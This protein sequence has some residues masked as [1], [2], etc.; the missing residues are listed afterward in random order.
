MLLTSQRAVPPLP[1]C[2]SPCLRRPT[3]RRPLSAPPTHQHRSCSGWRDELPQSP[4]LLSLLSLPPHVSLSAPPTSPCL[5]PPALPRLP[6]PSRSPTPPCWHPP[7]STA[8]THPPPSHVAL[9]RLPVCTPTAPLPRRSPTPPGLHPDGPPPTSLSP[10]SPC[11]Q[12][13]TVFDFPRRAC[14]E[15]PNGP[16]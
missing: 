5:H 3:P 6:A 12:P 2:T 1:V 13:Y 8:Y 7:A 15:K 9:P 4:P 10:R 16:H 14:I 11:L